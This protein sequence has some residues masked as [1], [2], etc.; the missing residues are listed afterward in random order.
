[1]KSPLRLFCI[2]AVTALAACGTSPTAPTR[3]PATLRA[4]ETPPPPPPPQ[5]EESRGI[6]GFGSGN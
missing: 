2:V 1:M 5:T 3:A 4:D 6:N